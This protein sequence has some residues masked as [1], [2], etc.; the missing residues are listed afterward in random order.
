MLFKDE[1]YVGVL[2]KT[3]EGHGKLIKRTNSS[4]EVKAEE[5]KA[6]RQCHL[7]L[8]QQIILGICE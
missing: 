4:I 8:I 5:S 2:T 1:G 3:V 7:M 6:K